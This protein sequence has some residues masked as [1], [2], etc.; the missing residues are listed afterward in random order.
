[1]SSSKAR[2]IR[3]C[4]P[5]VVCVLLAALAPGPAGADIESYAIVHDDASLEVRG[6]TIHLF[7]IHIPRG[8]HVCR[9]SIRPARC[10]TEAALALDFRI[11]S[12][13]RC[14]VVSRNRDRSLNA[15]CFVKGAGSVLEPDED[16]SA[17][18][19]R[20]GLAVALPD[21]PFEYQALERIAR[22][23]GRGV[24]SESFRQVR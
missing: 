22:A 15:R 19:L 24:W 9:G 17:Y 1:M 8:D 10:A 18:L 13:V 3:H 11:Q 6:R 16:L 23:Q 4:L 5:A 14:E 2:M 7:G 20:R 21:A 12:F